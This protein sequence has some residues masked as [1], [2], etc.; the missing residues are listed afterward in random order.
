MRRAL[1]EPKTGQ[2]SEREQ[3]LL[4]TIRNK[5]NFWSRKGK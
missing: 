4:V 2:A 5:V 1:A 3:K